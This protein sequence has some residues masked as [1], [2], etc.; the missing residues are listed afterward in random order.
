[1]S[2][3]L[4][5]VV[6]WRRPAASPVSSNSRPCSERAAAAAAGDG[7]GVATPPGPAVR[8]HALAAST[9]SASAVASTR[10]VPGGAV[11]FAMWVRPRGVAYHGAAMNLLAR[12]GREFRG[13]NAIASVA[14]LVDQRPI[15]CSLY[16][17]DRCNLDCA[18][19]TEYDNS[20]PH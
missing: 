14:R 20:V 4:P 17:T 8:R 11:A 9:A 2:F 1:M 13:Y 19:C 5:N 10:R 3:S 15:Q 16:V 12:A 6:A 7:D 18:Y